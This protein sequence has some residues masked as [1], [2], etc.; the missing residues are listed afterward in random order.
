MGIMDLPITVGRNGYGC[1]ETLYIFIPWTKT[2]TTLEC[3]RRKG[4]GLNYNS[5]NRSKFPHL[6]NKN[7]N[8][9]LWKDKLWD[10]LYY[11][12]LSKIVFWIRYLTS[13]RRFFIFWLNVHQHRCFFIQRTMVT[14]QDSV[15]P[16]LRDLRVKKY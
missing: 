1:V 9:F 7:M 12:L 6:K 3:L 4:E 10:V 8:L 2:L 13:V 11:Q 15:L 16:G 14:H 5:R